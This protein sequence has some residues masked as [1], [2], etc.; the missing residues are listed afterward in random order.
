MR[1][2]LLGASGQIG[3]EIHA[4]LRKNPSNEVLATSRKSSNEYFQFDPFKDDWSG[5]GKADV[6]INSVGQI[7]ETNNFSFDKVHRELTLLIIKNRGQLGNPRI[8]QISVV[9][10]DKNSPVEFLSTKGL[11]DE[12]LMRLENT[13]VVRAS[14]VCTPDTMMVRKMKMVYEM[15]KY[16]LGYALIPAGFLKHKIQPVMVQDLAIIL[17]RIAQADY[18]PKLIEVVGPHAISYR[19]LL[20]ILYKVKGKKPKLVEIPRIL[21][22]L[23]VKKIVSPVFPSVINKQQYYLLFQDNVG[24]KSEGENFL[25][26]PLSDTHEFW[27]N[28]F[29]DYDNNYPEH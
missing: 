29:K 6:L 9:G 26:S 27:Q 11:A 28:E 14:I 18:P 7:E 10:A 3:K 17:T 15:S 20:E 1:V 22:D 8:I 23:V 13:V 24:D 19:Q 2:I 21:T 5:L 4:A 16:S 12:E 25:G